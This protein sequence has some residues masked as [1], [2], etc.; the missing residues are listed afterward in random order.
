[1]TLSHFASLPNIE[2]AKNLTSIKLP[3][4]NLRYQFRLFLDRINRIDRKI[5]E[6]LPVE[7]L[8]ARISF[9]FLHSRSSTMVLINLYQNPRFAG[10]LLCNLQV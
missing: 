5:A 4:P 2:S 8:S 7:C 10:M 9:L 1:M 6:K 3:Y